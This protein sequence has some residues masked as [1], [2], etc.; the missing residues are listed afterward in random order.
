MVQWVEVVVVKAGHEFQSLIY[1]KES[2]TRGVCNPRFPVGRG[3]QGQENPWELVGQIAQ[4]VP[5]KIKTNILSH[6]R[7]K[8]RT[9]M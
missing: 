8:V 6:K 7:W 4:C 5:Q 1:M 3:R 2:D 9:Y